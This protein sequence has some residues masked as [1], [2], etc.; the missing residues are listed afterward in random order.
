MENEELTPPPAT[1]RQRGKCGEQP[2]GGRRHQHKRT[3]VGLPRECRNRHTGTSVF[4]WVFPFIMKTKQMPRRRVH[5]Y[6][7]HQRV[8]STIFILLC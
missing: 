8:L 5:D 2:P 4:G 1:V 6:Q 7:K 3:E